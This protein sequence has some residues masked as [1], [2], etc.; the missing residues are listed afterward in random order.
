MSASSSSKK[1]YGL[2]EFLQLLA[3]KPGDYAAITSYEASLD[4]LRR[5]LRER[6]PGV[7]IGRN[8]ATWPNGARLLFVRGGRGSGVQSMRGMRLESVLL[9]HGD[10]NKAFAP[11]LNA[12]LPLVAAGPDFERYGVGW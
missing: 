12:L 9:V 11:E 7:G 5:E 10:P 8:Y 3:D 4:W 6:V 2:P 1:R